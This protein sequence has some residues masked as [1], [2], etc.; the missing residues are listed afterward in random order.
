MARTGI[1]ALLVRLPLRA[2][3]PLLMVA[4][5]VAVL[6]AVF[7]V[8]ASRLTG[9]AI[10]S[11]HQRLGRATRQ[12]AA[13]SATSIAGRQPRYAVVADD[14]LVRR[15]LRDSAVPTAAVHAV[16]ARA[17]LP[18]DSGMPVELWT[19]DGRRVAF[20][21]N[22]VVMPRVGAGGT[23]LPAHIASALS[24]AYADSSDLLRTSGMFLGDGKVTLW[25][26]HLI[27]D[28]GRVTGYVTHQRRPLAGPATLDIL[29][30][31]S[32]YPVTLYYRNADSTVWA[33]VTGNPM[34]PLVRAGGVRAPSAQGEE[35]LTHEE[36]IGLSPLMVGMHVPMATLL[37]RPREIMGT[38]VMWSLVLIVVGASVSW[39]IANAFTGPLN[40]LRRA[41]ATLAAGDYQVRIPE[42]GSAEVRGL[43]A[44]FNEMTREIES[45][46]VALDAQ[47][48]RAE[49]ASSAKSDFL[50]MMSHELR[51]PLNAIG[52]YVDLLEMELRGPLTAGQR[53]D[54]A[55][56]KKN[57]QHLLTLIS[58][59]LDLARVEA[60]RV[61]YDIGPV[62]LRPFLGDLDAL[63]APRTSGKALHIDHAGAGDLAVLADAEKLRQILLNL[64]SNAIRHTPAGGQVR[65][66]VEPRPADVAIRVSDT[67]P[68]IPEEHHEVIF[69]P[70]VQLDRSLTQNREGLGL[71]L[72]ISRDLARG[73]SGE[74]VVESHDG[75][76]ARFLLTL[77]RTTDSTNGK[78]AEDDAAAAVLTPEKV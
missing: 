19:V 66:T 21:G 2:K 42:Q 11:A 18:A 23:R 56:I 51:T 13:L 20:V 58:S 14:S 63:I 15:A 6:G 53:G 8:T 65:L 74:L 45:A 33:T 55:R 52:G 43:A 68:G 47:R 1:A 60:G 24:A 73:M 50:A 10:D 17:A 54:L 27:R 9:S 76:G 64:L 59:V 38:L 72:A 7:I 75:A 62:A 35:L 28:Q 32:G 5:L 25:F 70:F 3:L 34:E 78:A 36:R 29:R 41:V 40:D 49:A 30:D 44:A 4:V 46:R 57:Q 39:A 22:D 16:L 77:P 61:T 26:V 12:I 48:R 71:G 31:L 37:A 69:E 67:G